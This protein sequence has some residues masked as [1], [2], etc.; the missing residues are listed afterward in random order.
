[1]WANPQKTA[2]LATFTNNILNGKN[3][4]FVQCVAKADI[5]KPT[6]E[7]MQ[8]FR[9]DLSKSRRKL[10]KFYIFSI[11]GTYSLCTCYCGG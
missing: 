11:K 1:M 6:L 10:L 9:L 7:N 8:C 4:F 3:Y 5:G 2:E